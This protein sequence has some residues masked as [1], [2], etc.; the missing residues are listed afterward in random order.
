LN[1]KCAGI[2]R[3]GKERKCR[4]PEQPVGKHFANADLDL[5]VSDGMSTV[6]SSSGWDNT[7]EYVDFVPTQTGT[8]TVYANKGRCDGTFSNNYLGMAWHRAP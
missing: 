2:N 7:F 4:D 5:R 8:Y 3:T 6:A 1:P